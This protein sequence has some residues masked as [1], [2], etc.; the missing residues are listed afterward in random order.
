MVEHYGNPGNLRNLL[1]ETSAAVEGIRRLRELLSGRRCIVWG[2]AIAA[3]RPA[4][5]TVFDM[6]ICHD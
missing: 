1:L 5:L 2:L 6:T 4:A 3:N